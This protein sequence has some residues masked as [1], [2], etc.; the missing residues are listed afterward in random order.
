MGLAVWAA[1]SPAVV[2]DSDFDSDSGLYSGFDYTSY[3]AS[4]LWV[5]AP[6]LQRRTQLAEKKEWSFSYSLVF[7]INCL[8]RFMFKY[9]A[10]IFISLILNHTVEAE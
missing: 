6:L 5:A 8:S 1:E 2:A 4:C 10:L 9:G 7:L 3:L